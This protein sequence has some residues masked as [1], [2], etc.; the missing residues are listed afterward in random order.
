MK[1]LVTGG[2][3]FIGS[4]LVRH[5]NKEYPDYE[6]YNLDKLTYAGHIEYLANLGKNV[7]TIHGDI[8]EEN[9]A[10]YAMKGVDVVVHLAPESHVDGSNIVPDIFKKINVYV[11]EA[12]LTT[13]V[14][15]APKFFH[16]V[17]NY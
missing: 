1:I 14:K 13:A 16:H 12:L 4:H 17:I 15:A 3:G 6:I 7:V 5:L 2:Y 11:T 9:A 8:C 10:E